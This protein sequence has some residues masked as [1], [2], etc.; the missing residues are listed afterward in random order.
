MDNSFLWQS[1][2]EIGGLENQIDG[3][4]KI[5][6]SREGVIPAEAGIL[7]FQGVPDPRACPGRDPGFAGLRVKTVKSK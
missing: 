5:R 1:P 7:L 6:R 2:Q 3:L 4:A